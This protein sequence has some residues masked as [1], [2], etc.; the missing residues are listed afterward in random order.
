MDLSVSIR[1]K[2]RDFFLDVSFQ[3]SNEIFALL[4]AS[5]SGKSMTLKIIA[6]IE[7]PDEGKII[8]NGR[9]LFDS[10][11]K[12]NLPPQSRRLGYLFQN[13][14]LFPNMTVAE[15]ILFAAV[16]NRNEKLCSLDENLK[17]FQLRGLENSYPHELSGGQQQRVALARILTSHAEFLLLDEPFSALDSYLKW[18]LELELA[19]IFKSYNGAAILVSHDRDEVFRLAD[20]IAVLNQG[21]IDA[22]NGKHELF[23]NPQTVSA[24]ILTGCK[25]ISSAKKIADDKIFAED[26]QVTLSVNKKIPDDLKFIGIHSHA[27]EV[28]RTGEN[29]FPAELVQ[30]IEDTRSIILTVKLVADGKNLIRLEVGKNFWRNAKRDDLCIKIP[31][32]KIIFLNG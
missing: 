9:V 16:G 30:E 12:L 10:E 5:G 8:L 15:N 7:T 4:G 21:K 22:I 11:K 24:A 18:N 25:N 29:I 28:S 31:P 3:T 1:K 17:R 26:W 14:A 27:L 23:D 32:E 13:Y 6:G 20:K 19:E 2:L